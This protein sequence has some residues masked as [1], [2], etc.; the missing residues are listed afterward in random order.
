MVCYLEGLIKKLAKQQHSAALAQLASRMEAPLELL[1]ALL[2]QLVQT[3]QPAAGEAAEAVAAADVQA[4]AEPV[5]G[6]GAG[7]GARAGAARPASESF[8]ADPVAVRRALAELRAVQ[9]VLSVRGTPRP[10][11]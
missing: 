8:A 2:T 4:E 7:A 5:D 6:A 9:R 1:T 3:P 10:G 11:A